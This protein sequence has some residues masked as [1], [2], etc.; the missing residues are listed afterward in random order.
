MKNSKKFVG[1]AVAAVA[2]VAVVLAVVFFVLPMIGGG[3]VTKVKKA[4]FQ[5]LEE[6]SF[7]IRISSGDDDNMKIKVSYDEEDG[8]IYATYN[9]G[10]TEYYIVMDNKYEFAFRAREYDDELEVSG[11]MLYHLTGIE[12]DLYDAAVAA[13]TGD[14][15]KFYEELG[16]ALIK[17]QKVNEERFENYKADFD[18]EDLGE[19]VE[20]LVDTLE[21]RNTLEECLD[22]EKEREDGA[23]VY[24]FDID[25]YETMS[26]LLKAMK[27]R[28]E[29]KGLYED[30][31]EE[32]K[33]DKEDLDEDELKI[34]VGIDGGKL[35]SVVVKGESDGDEFRFKATIDDIGETDVKLPSEV[36]DELK[37]MKEEIKEQE[38]EDEAKHEKET[39]AIPQ[40]EE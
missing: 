20:K 39:A 33:N 14:E 28:Y 40:P 16:S 24:K 27:S 11:A 12:A 36:K 2:V 37:K 10:S 17:D 34:N 29:D 13:L 5:T 9:V 35:S 38:S 26:V 7:T 8:T 31:K 23:T 3:P 19:L 32:L 18:Y 1:I 21:E 6:K 4:I 30:L 15:E 25:K 22:P